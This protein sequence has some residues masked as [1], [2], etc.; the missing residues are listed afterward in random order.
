MPVVILTTSSDEVDIDRAYG[1]GANT[2]FTELARL[3][4]VVKLAEHIRAYWFEL[5]KLPKRRSN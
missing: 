3:V 1:L 2:F 4:D 5:A